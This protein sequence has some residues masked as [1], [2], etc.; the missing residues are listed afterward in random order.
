MKLWILACRTAIRRPGF[1]AAVALILALGIGAN[2]AVFCMIDAVLLKPLPYP[3]P[4]RL[5]S[6]NEAS[7]AKNERVSLIAP[8]RLED[9]NRMTRAFEAIAGSYSENVTDT[10]PSEPERLAGRRVSPRFFAVYGT[11][12]LAGRTFSAQEEV[13]NGPGAAVI[14]YNF[15]TRRYRQNAGVIGRRLILAGKDYTVVGVM[16]RDFAGS[17]IDLWLP[18]Q[19]SPFLLRQRAARFL[20]G[21]GRMKPGVTISQATDDLSRAQKELEAQ[22]PRTDR[23][24]SVV[25]RDLKDFRVGDYRRALWFV[26]GAVA[27][28]LLIAIANISGLMLTQLQRRA[29]ELAI[30]TSLGASRWQVVGGVM[31]EVIVISA[32]GVA[33]GCGA[34]FSIVRAMSTLI[35][36]LPGAARLAVDWRALAF[37]A[38]TGV[39]AAILCGL[40]PAIQ[41]TG[42]DV[43]A[44]LAQSGR[45][46]S[47]GRHQWQRVL[48]AG[49]FALTLLLLAGAGLM[50]RSYYNLSHV[51]P[52]F[53][54]AHALTF[55]TGA[56]WD[57]DRKRVGQLQEDL[58]QNLRRQP[59]VEAAGFANFLPASGATLRYQLT[60]D[61]S[62]PGEESGAIN[63]GER[64]IAAGYLQAIG[65]P[66]LAGQDCPSLRQAGAGLPKSLVNRR[67]VELYSDGENLV[68]RRFQWYPPS[69][70]LKPFEIA[71]IVG[72]IREDNLRT[73][74]GPYVYVCLGPGDWPDPEYVVRTQGDPRSS[75]ASIR[76]LVR[77]LAP[78]RAVF[79]LKPLQSALDS[80]LDQPRLNTRMLTL[81][82]LAAVILASIGLYGLLTLVV[83]GRTRDIGVRLTL[84]ASPGHIVAEILS[85]IVRVLSAGVCAGLLLTAT[86]NRFLGAILFGVSP[87][88]PATLGATVVLLCAV[89]AVA[90]FAPAR[91]AARIDPLESIRSE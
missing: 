55:H 34:A 54:P 75:L 78:N 51:D 31:R 39:L 49:Q 42:A 38:F 57:E 33:L 84:G 52:G 13:A 66:L 69:P 74:T 43:A 20:S 35:T 44:L 62:T 30:R 64:G 67:F 22:F 32:L 16:P 17:D 28:L 48:V 68:G 59:G 4:D 11:R 21:V 81:F 6:V 40:L 36:A 53:E 85:G 9:W 87:I 29:R 89:A 91:R 12:P 19:F 26:F 82:A 83:I 70:N 8:A 63:V 27:L 37:A 47:G 73:T 71:G 1:A 46:G 80:S 79:G 25:V 76:P 88:D 24:W 7:A 58:L 2:T 18:A 23:D 56:A 45:G 65:A 41:A 5:V 50:L 10:S 90:T 3:A 86:A 15:W 60:L 72:D 61:R 14:S 77:Q